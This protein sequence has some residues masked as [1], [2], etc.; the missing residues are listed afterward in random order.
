TF[1][2]AGA[3]GANLLTHLLGQD[4]EEL[5]RKIQ[6]YRHARKQHGHDEKT[7]I[8]TVMLHTYVGDSIEE[9]ERIVEQPFVE[10]LK[11]SIGLS[12]ILTEETGLK[13]DS[14][15][16]KEKERIINNAFKRYYKTGSLIGTRSTCSEMVMKLKSIGVNEI[17][18]LV[19][20]GVEPQKV[21]ASLRNLE[22]LKSY[23]RKAER[24]HK[25]VTVMQS[26]PSFI[27]LMQE[28]DGSQQLLR[29]LRLLLI[30]GEA[31]PLSLVR[32]L[33]H[34]T[35][36]AIWNMYGPTETTIWSCIH[37][38]PST[39]EK[40]IVGKP[41]LNTQVYILDKDQQLVPV[42]VTGELYI[43]GEG[44]AHG[45]WKRADLTSQ[46]FIANPFRPGEVMYRTG[47]LARWL[48]GGTIE[49]AGRED[50]QLKVRGYRIEPGEIEVALLGFAG[51]KEAVVMAR[52]SALIAYIVAD[53]SIGIPELRQH[54]VQRLP[55]YMIPSHFVQLQALPLTPNGKVDR[56]ALP[57]LATDTGCEYTGPSTETEEKLVGIWSEILKIDKER[58][59]IRAN[60]FELGGHSLNAMVL[61]RKILKEFNVEI[62]LQKIFVINTIEQIAD[63][64][65]NER[66]VKK[67]TRS[68]EPAGEEIIID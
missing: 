24:V 50:H 20:F 26:T 56:K 41:I 34:D 22:A 9:V 51:I 31:A 40:I 44:V 52:E 1:I 64:I 10:Y 43:G 21:L 29:S 59:S 42:G 39:V 25:P 66:W 62:L 53:A 36:A 60:F 46:R 16:E 3:A 17:A 33:K 6:L 15:P 23:F 47:D 18:C 58:V 48:P 5:A 38:F 61:V 2:N 12:R 54:L 11:S 4:V 7:G 27:K 37:E 45:Y 65:D 28:G 14:I 30:G 63:I 32:Q 67:E 68:T 49:L 8:I 57:G 35:P 55:Q 13:E 19:D